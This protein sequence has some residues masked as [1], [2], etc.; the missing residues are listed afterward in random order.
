RQDLLIPVP[1]GA[2]DPVPAPATLTL[3]GA[4]LVALVRARRRGA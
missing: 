2:P 1:G 4:G 3:L